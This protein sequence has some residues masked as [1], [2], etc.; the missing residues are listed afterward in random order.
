MKMVCDICRPTKKGY[1][2]FFSK[3]EEFN[4]LKHYY[5][6]D[7]EDTFQIIDSH[8]VWLL[9]PAFFSFIDYANVHLDSS[10][11]YAVESNPL[12][13]LENRAHTK[14][15]TEFTSERETAWI[16]LLIEQNRITT[17]YQPIIRLQNNKPIIA[18]YELLSRGMDE[19]G[20]I[21]PPSINVDL[22]TV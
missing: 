15:I 16:D 5:L 3:E 22:S 17:H 12:H 8:T 9:E 20:N 19:S 14:P 7:T 11:I 4:Q 1:T 2:L 10:S 13:P 18:G 6:D 21:I